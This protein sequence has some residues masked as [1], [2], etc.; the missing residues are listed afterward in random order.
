MRER[1][2][3]N[4]STHISLEALAREHKAK[5]PHLWTSH[6]PFLDAQFCEDALQREH[7]RL[8]VQFSY[9]G[10]LEDRRT[11]WHGSYLDADEKYIHLGVDVNVPAGTPVFADNPGRV[12]SV[13]TDHPEEHGWGTRV[14]IRLDNHPVYLIYAHL[15]PRTH[16][17]ADDTVQ[18]GSS[19]G[20][21]G[22][23]E[24]N[25]GWF[26]HW[27]GQ[28]VAELTYH[29]LLIDKLRSL[30][31]YGRVRDLTL[32]RSEYPDPLQYMRIR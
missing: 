1:T 17:R 29:R 9:G 18:A 5:H 27:H 24:N 4:R 8:G 28:A 25:G 14:I 7:E 10:Y 22:S 15:H 30:D 26:T 31:G 11:L 32:H 20:T 13:G 12:V 16:V 2:L 19:L 23:V 3:L 21:V 6:S